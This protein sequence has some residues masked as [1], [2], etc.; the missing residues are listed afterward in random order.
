[1]MRNSSPAHLLK[2]YLKLMHWH[3]QRGR[4]GASDRSSKIPI[5]QF[6]SVQT[7]SIIKYL[8]FRWFKTVSVVHNLYS[9]QHIFQNPLSYLNI[10]E[11]SKIIAKIGN[12]SFSFDLY[13]PIELQL[14]WFVLLIISI[15]TLT[16][17]HFFL[18]FFE[19][20]RIFFV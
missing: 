3:S 18:N 10:V 13:S 17:V 15:K 6:F 11:L 5:S 14:F 1:M 7:S 19:I 20:F 8:P 9:F 12:T 16:R 4:F 2:H